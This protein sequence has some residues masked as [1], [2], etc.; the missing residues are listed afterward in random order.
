V[1]NTLQEMRQRKFTIGVVLD[2]HGGVEGVVTVKDLVAELVGELQ[3]EY[4][5]GTPSVVKIGAAEWLADGRLPLEDLATEIDV[6]L[7]DGPYS[8]V[9]GMFMAL[10]GR[11][12][13]DGDAVSIADLRLTVLQ[14]DRNRV[15]RIRVER[16]P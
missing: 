11:V 12:P 1:L 4:D 6:E 16:Q 9:A 14:M 15:D 2:E 5:P 13:D 8:T 7:P 3:D 10:S